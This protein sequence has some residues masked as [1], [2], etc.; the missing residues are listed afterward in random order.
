MARTNPQDEEGKITYGQYWR[1]VKAI[2][3]DAMK[4]AR[5]SPKDERRDR[6]V[7]LAEEAVDGH[8]WVIYTWANPYV[9]IHSRHEDSIFD[10]LGPQTWESYSDAMMKMAA[11][12][13][14]G[15]VME[16]LEELLSAKGL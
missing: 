16:D 7:Q 3:K 2:A 9:L 8:E 11:W 12:A 4:E 6:A 5:Q 15:D 1:Q 10:D 14:R 13:L